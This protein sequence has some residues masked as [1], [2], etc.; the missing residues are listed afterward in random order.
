M[1]DLYQQFGGANGIPG[2]RLQFNQRPDGAPLR[3]LSEA[4][5][6]FWQENGYVIVPDAVPAEN[7]EAA[8]DLLWEFQEMDRRDPATWYRNPARFM[9][10]VE[11][12]GSGMVEVYNHQALWNNRQHP[13]VYEAFVDI[14]GREDL[15][16]TIDRANL[17]VPNKA[18]HEFS[19]FIHW[20]VDTSLDPLPVNVQGVLSLGDATIEMGGFQC[21]PSLYRNFHEWVKTQP[22]DRNPYQPDIA[23]FEI[24]KVET[25][26]GDLLIWNSL[27]AHGIRTNHS[28]RPRLAQ[29]IAMTPAEEENLELRQWRIRSWRDRVAPEGYAFPGDPRNWEQTRYERARLT[30]LGEKLLGL[31]D[32][33]LHP[34]RTRRERGEH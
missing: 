34:P 3:V 8:T 28:V 26:A 32:W 15:W 30:T 24:V 7:L 33:S 12:R 21:V 31:R 9:E 25:R 29:Y 11:L 27:L 14:W 22:P 17:N 13:R 6:Q 19:G 20:D 2:R 16:V 1:S 10:M 5:W 18:G 23:D 4:D